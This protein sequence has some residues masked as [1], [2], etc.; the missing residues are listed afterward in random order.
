[1]INRRSH[2]VATAG[3]AQSQQRPF[4]SSLQPRVVRLIVAK[5]KYRSSS[6]GRG[7]D[8]RTLAASNRARKRHQREFGLPSSGHLRIRCHYGNCQG[9]RS[10]KQSNRNRHTRP[11]FH[12]HSFSLQHSPIAHIPSRGSPRYRKEACES[13]CQPTRNTVTGSNRIFT[14]EVALREDNANTPIRNRFSVAE[15]RV[16][17]TPLP[18]PRGAETTFPS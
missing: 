13:I 16:G 9:D 7:Y 3:A 10:G 5:S 2:H 8:E 18:R 4:H 1:M 15:N 14:E 12:L 17:P 11:G 6:P